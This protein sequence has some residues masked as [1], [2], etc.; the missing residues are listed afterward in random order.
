MYFW[1]LGV[2]KWVRIYKML[3]IV[4]L[5]YNAIQMLVVISL[6]C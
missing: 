1:G 5:A 3:R 2:C 6:C 4:P